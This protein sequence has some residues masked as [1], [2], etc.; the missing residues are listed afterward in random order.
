MDAML[1][2]SKVHSLMG[3]LLIQA[4]LLTAFTLRK[5]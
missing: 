5:E 4:I 2:L 3:A 1:I